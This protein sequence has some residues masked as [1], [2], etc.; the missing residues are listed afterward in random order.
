VKL[1]VKS[2]LS[3]DIQILTGKSGRFYLVYKIDDVVVA[4]L[5]ITIESL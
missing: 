2:D 4:D 3:V 1:I 5:G